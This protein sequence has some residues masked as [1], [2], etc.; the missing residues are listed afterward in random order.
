MKFSGSYTALITPFRGET[1]DYPTLQ[2]FVDWQIAEGTDGVVP[3]GTTGESPTL[4]HDEH[5]RVVKAT[6]EAAKGRAVVMAGTGSNSTQEAVDFI[7]HA[8]KAGA[9]AALVVCPYYN[10]PTQEGLYQHYK[11]IHD[12]SGLPIVIYNIPGRTG[13]DMSIDTMK[14]LAEL[15]RIAGVKDATADLA[16]PLRTRLAIGPD[17]AQFSGEDITALAFLVQGGHGCISV[18]SNVAPKL[19]AEMQHAWAAGEVKTAMAISERLAPLAD[20]LFAETS[21][22]PVKYAAELLG[23]SSATLRSPLLPATPAVRAR[24]EA[25]LRHAGV[26]N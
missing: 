7:R 10:R 9:D 13:V 24:V 21:P 23:K 18:V 8:E 6:V 26:L 11:T 4:S 14:R 19:C 15:P 25:A 3:C 12:A 5:K 22:T 16:R 2:A 17:F 1:V 20:A